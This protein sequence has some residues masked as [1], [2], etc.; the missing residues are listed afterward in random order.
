VMRAER[1][2]PKL[3]GGSSHRGNKRGSLLR[4]LPHRGQAAPA[5]I[6]SPDGLRCDS[7]TASASQALLPR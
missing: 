7:G 3:D 4:I 1:G 6:A 5:T 2:S